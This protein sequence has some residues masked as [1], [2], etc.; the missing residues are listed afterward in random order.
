MTIHPFPPSPESH[1]EPLVEPFAEPFDEPLDEPFADTR[2][3]LDGCFDEETFD[4]EC[5]DDLDG[6]LN[7]YGGL[8]RSNHLAHRV[9][10]PPL[11]AALTGRDLPFCQV[12]HHVMFSLLEDIGDFDG[13]IAT[14]EF[15]VGP[16]AHLRA[17]DHWLAT[18][19]APAVDDDSRPAREAVADHSLALSVAMDTNPSLTYGSLASLAEVLL[20]DVLDICEPGRSCSSDEI[21]TLAAATLLMLAHLRP[22]A[23]LVGGARVWA[24]DEHRHI[25]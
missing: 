3:D 9:V 10:S 18:H 12:F 8:E 17:A 14:S 21:E 4:D 23:R 15:F 6:S 13:L 16:G 19:P 24:V 20:P 11:L 5:F 25:G 22:L 1:P 2:P 7:R